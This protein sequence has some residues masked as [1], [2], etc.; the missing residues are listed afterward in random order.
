MT[1]T[2]LRPNQSSILR[3]QIRPAG[4][5]FGL[6]ALGLT[7]CKKDEPAAEPAKTVAG[8]DATPTPTGAKG[9]AGTKIEADAPKPTSPVAGLSPADALQPPSSA[10][11]RGEVLG[12]L[13]L[14]NPSVFLAEV[15]NQVA[16]AAQATYVDETVL[17]TMGGAV[18]GSRSKLATNLDLTK[19]MGCALVDLAS[20]PLPL[21]CVMGYTGGA[22]SLITDLG[23][24]GKQD[25]AAGHAAKYVVGG[26]ELFV[27]DAAGQVVVSN[28]ADAFAK[29]RAYVETNL[30]ARAASVAT[31]LEFVAFPS[32]VLTRYSKELAPVLEA[33]GKI[34][35]PSGGG[36]FADALTAYGMKAN[37][38]SIENIRGFDQITV[39]LGLEPS[40]FVARFAMFPTPGSQAETQAKIAAAGPLDA[41][42]VRNLPQ[43]SWML[44]GLNAHLGDAMN[45]GAFKDLR[46]VFVDAYAEA[47]G[48]DKAATQGSVDTFM[49]ELKATY[50]GQSSFALMH[51]PGTLGGFVL[52]SGLQSGVAARES[53]KTWAS[54]F[55]PEA[56]LGAEAA[57]KLTWS[58]QFDATKIGDV[59]IDRFVIEPG[60]DEKA[61]MRAEGG[62]TLAEWET[63]LGGLKL[64]INRAEHDGKVAW[65]VGPGSDDKYAQSV[66]EALAGTNALTSNAGVTTVLDRSPGASAIVAFDVKGMF[67]WLSEIVPPAERAKLPTTIGNNLSDVF[68]T[69]SYGSTGAQSGEFLVSQGLIDQ[70]RALAN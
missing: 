52:V 65:I 64:V 30:V 50:S 19:P 27:D 9:S 62:A 57:K 41:G 22:E 33:M 17:R 24:E 40:G 15:K 8:K 16:P 32:A 2:M 54:T 10:L 59:A 29:G 26:Q 5:V 13:L 34:P 66:V 20:A 67:G 56:V 55:T 69:S 4:L 44:M 61:K 23:A 18:L 28:H 38:Q 37:A 14:T 42:F 68:M 53:W 46:N 6:L 39:A 21:V 36:A 12:H 45:T 3:S 47:V 35:T 60:A 58:F 25:D 1:S 48:K 7:G 11:A 49:A 63:R 70:I 43:D 51:Q 31:D